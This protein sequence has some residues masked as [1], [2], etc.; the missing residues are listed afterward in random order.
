[1]GFCCC[2][3]AAGVLVAVIAAIEASKPS[4]IYLTMLM[5]DLLPRLP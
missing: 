2:C 4:Q 3:A 5:L 1:L